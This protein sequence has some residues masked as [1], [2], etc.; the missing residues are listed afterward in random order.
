M[1]KYF[2]PFVIVSLSL[3]ACV[4][5]PEQIAGTYKGTYTSTGQINNSGNGTV[6]ITAVDENEVDMTFSSFGNV[7]VT[8]PQVV[9]EQLS[10]S[11]E[12]EL[13]LDTL[14]PFGKMCT[15]IVSYGNLAFFYADTISTTTISVTNFIKQ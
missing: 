9:V 8:I 15:G 12:F 14:P 3:F 6:V 11:N 13:I 4:T 5:P 2:I 7:P 10:N 1:K